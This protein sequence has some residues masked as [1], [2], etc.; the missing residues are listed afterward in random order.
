[1]S[2]YNIESNPINFAVR[3]IATRQDAAENYAI[4][5]FAATNMSQ[6]EI[7]QI[8]LASVQKGTILFNTTVNAFWGYNGVA[9][10]PLA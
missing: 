8:P 5:A 3:A 6:A 2:F 9:W 10:V 1:M 7:L 4:K